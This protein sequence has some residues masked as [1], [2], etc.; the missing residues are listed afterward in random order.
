MNSQRLADSAMLSTAQHAPNQLDETLSNSNVLTLFSQAELMDCSLAS[1]LQ[2]A[3]RRIPN[4]QVALHSFHKAI[5]IH[6][7]KYRLALGLDSVRCSVERRE[8]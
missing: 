4:S 2:T 5:C 7:Y 6:K 8:Q 3:A 1:V